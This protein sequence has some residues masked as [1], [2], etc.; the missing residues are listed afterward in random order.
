MSWPGWTFLPDTLM[1][2]TPPD[3]V[4]G[5]GCCPRFGLGDWVGLF[6]DEA[7]ETDMDEALDDVEPADEPRL[8]TDG[9]ERSRFSPRDWSG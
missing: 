2:V 4:D 6:G 7:L 9:V 5:F 3:L 1:P 8:D